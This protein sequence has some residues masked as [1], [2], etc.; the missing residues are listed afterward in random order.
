MH[1]AIL[2]INIAQSVFT[3]I[4]TLTKRPLNT[5]DKILSGWL[6]MVIIL[7]SLNLLRLQFPDDFDDRLVFRIVIVLAF[8]SF[9]YLYVKYLT[10]GNKKFLMK[11]F[12][13]FVTFGTF[14]ISSLILAIKHP[15]ATT[16]NNIISSFKLFPLLSVFVFFL[17]FIFY[18]YHTIKLINRFIEKRDDYFS[19]HSANLSIGWIRVLVYIFYSYFTL[20]MILGAFFR[21]TQS[22][23]DVS[24]FMSFGYTIFLYI[25]TFK[26]YKQSQLLE[27]PRQEKASGNSYK[28][29]GLKDTDAKNYEKSIVSHMETEKPWLN[30]EVSVGDISTQLNIPQHYI[31]QVLN[32]RLKRNFYTLINEYR[33]NEVI[34]LLSIEKY[35]NWSLTAIAYE[36]GFNSKSSF[37]SFFKKHTGKTPSEY[38]Q[39]ANSKK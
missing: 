32:E 11:D 20:A 1:E 27:I 23:F 17:S 37:N 13:H 35:K 10:L 31:T 19:F 7:F 2:H 6:I 24:L 4:I 18:G 15:S 12:W 9:L 28:K 38:R 26:G 21:F 22:H 34:R 8:P 30:P 33:T 29:S 16:T 36:A 5:I 25:I 39:L 14:L 3:A